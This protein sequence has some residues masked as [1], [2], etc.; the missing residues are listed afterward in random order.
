MANLGV[1]H[2]S[3]NS[4]VAFK[5]KILIV[6]KEP[7]TLEKGTDVFLGGQ[8]AKV[9]KACKTTIPILRLINW[10]GIFEQSIVTRTAKPDNRLTLMIRS[11]PATRDTFG[12]I[13]R[14][15]YIGVRET[16]HFVAWCK[17]RAQYVADLP[18]QES[19]QKSIPP[20]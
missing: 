1:L 18:A 15:K 19:Q 11:S 10:L 6:D 9:A 12:L 20:G 17:H 3:E 2:F 7:A 5:D 13:G 14:D 4:K 8:I 16:D